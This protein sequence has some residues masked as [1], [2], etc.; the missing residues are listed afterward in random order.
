MKKLISLSLAL[1]FALSCVFAAPKDTLKVLVIANS[2]GTDCVEQNLHEIALADGHMLVVGNMV[3]GGCSLERHWNNA[4][5]NKADYSYNKVGMDGRLVKRTKTTLAYA[6][7]DEPWDIITF[8]QKSG[9]SGIPET[10]EPYLTNL[11]KY[12]G[13]RSSAKVMLNQTWA[14]END[15]THKEFAKY[16]NN[17][18]KMYGAICDAYKQA[19]EAHSLE[20]IPTGTAVQ[21]SRKTFDGGNITRD[22]YHLNLWYGRYLA[23]CTWYE[24]LYGTSVVGNS[25]V[26]KN[27]PEY[28]IRHAQLCAHE[29]C[30]HPFEVCPPEG[31]ESIPCNVLPDNIPP[32]TL[33][34]PLTMQDGR[35]VETAEQWYTERRPELYRLFETEMFGRAP[36]R[37][38]VKYDTLCVNE[39]ALD[40]KALRTEVNIVFDGTRWMTLLIY[41]PADA[42]GPV[43][44]F[45]GVNFKG[46][47]AVSTD[48][49]IHM[50]IE[51]GRRYGI[52]PQFPRGDAA[53]RW[54]IEEILAR[55][56]A[57]VTFHSR[58]VDP[59]FDDGF[60]NGVH[61]LSYKEGQNCPA[62]DEWGTIAAW[63]WGL[64]RA[65]DYVETFDGIDASK[66]AVIGHSRLGKT[67]LWAGAS[68]ERF[69]IV[70]SNDSGC[71]GAALS[72]RAFGET[73]KAVNYR[74][75][76]WFCANFKKY[77]GHEDEL[78]F[79]QHEL[80]ALVAPRALYVA[81]AE[82]DGWADPVGERLSLQEAQKVYD[83]LG[84]SRTKIGYHIREGKHGIGIEDW[85]HYLDFADIQFGK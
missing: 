67:S 37:V 18:G 45:M 59:D 19:M 71:G 8:H 5:T 25:Y 64:S 7:K 69:A 74:F 23:A 34:D 63:S 50:P 27:V 36:G 3:I 40:G 65:M 1:F 31:E 12:V 62:P 16:D 39:P 24:T 73:L 61:P 29:A 22:G 11:I 48:P 54:P 77:C 26:P 2:F 35:K 6:L 70:I 52:W 43:P 80:L 14:Y 66:V 44:A 76:H 60:R 82:G 46:N 56:Y 55:G 21:I 81:S 57:V 38:P 15:A 68:D 4:R 32:Y 78:P 28:R 75:P 72:R 85:N 20:I 13:K 84:L 33:P 17:R 47:H 51:P 30:K 53:S 58:D 9:D 42:K 79:D 10:Y 49:G 41:T 83:F